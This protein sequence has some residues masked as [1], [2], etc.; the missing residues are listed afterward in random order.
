M[1][2]APF[3]DMS[4]D[5][6]LTQE[7]ERLLDLALGKGSLPTSDSELGAAAVELRSFVAETRSKLGEFDVLTEQ[8][9]QEAAEQVSMACHDKVA[10]PGLLGGIVLRLEFFRACLK[11]NVALRI[12]AASL[13]VHL[14]AL[15]VLAW[16]AFAKPE[17]RFLNVRIEEPRAV[18]TE[19]PGVEELDSPQVL[20]DEDLGDVDLGLGSDF[21]GK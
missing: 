9:L 1:K 2:S 19:D 21:E 13:L 3:S 11:N 15:P 20:E 17:P 16:L 14:T 10:Q 6:K 18:L 7:Q 4:E 5:P 8:S 12:A